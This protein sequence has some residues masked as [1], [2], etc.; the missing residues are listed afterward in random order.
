MEALEP[1]PGPAAHPAVW[2]REVAPAPVCLASPTTLLMPTALRVHA[3][4]R[5]GCGQAL[6]Q[7]HGRPTSALLPHNDHLPAVGRRP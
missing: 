3:C 1:Q 2:T 4:T 5:E 6:Q 7:Q